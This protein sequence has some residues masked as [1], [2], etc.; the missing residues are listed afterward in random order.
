MR[1]DIS[2]SDLTIIGSVHPHVNEPRPIVV[3]RRPLLG[4]VLTGV[5]LLLSRALVLAVLLGL[6][7]VL[8]SMAVPG[9]S[10]HGN[11]VMPARMAP[12]VTPGPNSHCVPLGSPGDPELMYRCR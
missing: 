5:E 11:P 10:M 2:T 9:P 12:G 3:R 7:F 6:M 1:R 8:V 4:F